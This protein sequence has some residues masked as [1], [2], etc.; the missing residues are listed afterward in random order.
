MVENLDYNVGRIRMALKDM[1][2]DRETY[3][4]FFSDHG[5]MLWSHAQTGKSSPWEES[6][7]HSV[8]YRQSGGWC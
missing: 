7:P 4:I 5:D 1:G 2:V 6:D 8:Y 3:V